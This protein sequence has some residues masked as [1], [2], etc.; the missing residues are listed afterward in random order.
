MQ[1]ST[2]TV[3]KQ[4]M[5]NNFGSLRYMQS[6]EEL[7][8]SRS[9]PRRVCGIPG[10]GSREPCGQQGEGERGGGVCPPVLHHHCLHLPIL[11]LLPPHWTLPAAS[12]SYPRHW[13]PRQQLV[14]LHALL[15]WVHVSDSLSAMLASKCS[16]IMI[17][18]NALQMR[19][20]TLIHVWCSKR[21]I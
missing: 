12:C 19:R 18:I 21:N 8:L 2:N 9:L 1:D 15:Q 7:L 13:R 17:T 11:R 14:H 4:N 10:P 16:I 6:V 3:S 20:I 5:T